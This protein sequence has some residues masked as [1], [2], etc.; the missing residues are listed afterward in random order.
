VDGGKRDRKKLR[1][2]IL[3]GKKFNGTKKGRIFSQK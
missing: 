1:K 3:G 2:T